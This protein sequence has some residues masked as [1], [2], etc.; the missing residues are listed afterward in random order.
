MASAA[1]QRAYRSQPRSLSTRERVLA[2]FVQHDSLTT[3]QL[4]RL[5]GPT[6]SQRLLHYQLHTLIAR[7]QIIRAPRQPAQDDRSL[8]VYR[9]VQHAES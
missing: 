1:Y 4:R 2:L 3:V 5:L 9:L 8:F 6:Y 7:K